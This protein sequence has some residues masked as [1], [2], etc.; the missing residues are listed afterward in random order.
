MGLN[1][2]IKGEVDMHG[3]KTMDLVYEKAIKQE[4]KLRAISNR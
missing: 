1:N 4:Q 2:K 3:P